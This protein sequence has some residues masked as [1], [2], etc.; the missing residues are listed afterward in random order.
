MRLQ[1]VL[2]EEQLCEIDYKRAFATGILGL[3]AAGNYSYKLPTHGDP[4]QPK[5]VAPVRDEA[6][7]L[8]DKILKKYKVDPKLALQV[9]KLA[10]K[11]EKPVFPKA[12]DILCIVGIESSFRPHAISNLKKDPAMG[13][14]Q[15]RPGVHKLDS[16]KLGGDIEHQIEKSAEILNKYNKHLKNKEAAIIA[17]NVGPGD[18]RKGNYNQNYINKF[19]NEKQ[20][21]N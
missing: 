19:K 10:K 6:Q 11:H 15:I 5:K 4:Y 9:A 18:Y 21:Y 14:T 2:T 17:Y 13:L 7:Q 1:E 16:K 3:A 8:A 12:E 20:L